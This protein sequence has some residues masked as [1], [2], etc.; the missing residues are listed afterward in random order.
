MG[1]I[2][3]LELSPTGYGVSRVMYRGEEVHL[4]PSPQ[5]C[6]GLRA[7]DTQICGMGT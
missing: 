4:Q 2:G 5:N 3:L 1:D 6:L 7:C